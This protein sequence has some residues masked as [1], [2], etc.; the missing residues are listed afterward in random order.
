[1][2][3]PWM[4]GGSMDCLDSSNDQIDRCR[5]CFGI[6]RGLAYLHEIDIVHGDLKA[7]NVL[8]SND[9]EA[10]LTDFG[11]AALASSTLLFTESNSARS[12]FSVRWAAPEQLEGEVT[13]SREA[14]IYSLGMEIIS[15]QQPYAYIQNEAAVIVAILVKRQ[16]PKRPEDMIPADS[17]RGEALWSLLESCWSWNPKDRP[18]ALSVVKEVSTHPSLGPGLTYNTPLDRD[19][20]VGGLA[21]KT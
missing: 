12:G 9:G 15:R 19:D 20:Q 6:A 21:S 17:S 3:S 18:V 14:D 16:R 4:G 8:L 13:C 11:S 7:G 2:V 5:L 10:Q 1:M